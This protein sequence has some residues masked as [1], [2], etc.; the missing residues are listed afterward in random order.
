[1]F[2]EVGKRLFPRTVVSQPLYPSITSD[3]NT[4]DKQEQQAIVLAASLLYNGW[5]LH[6]SVLERREKKNQTKSCMFQVAFS[7]EDSKDSSH[8]SSGV[9]C[10][11]AA[12]FSQVS[13]RSL[14]LQEFEN[15][16]SRCLGHLCSAHFSRPSFRKFSPYSSL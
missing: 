10:Q 3:S 4:Q 6:S 11:S 12:Q 13:C 5:R 9:S 7:T 14:L 16:C 8:E 1:M 2:S 15:C